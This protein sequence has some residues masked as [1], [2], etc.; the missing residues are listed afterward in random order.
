[1]TIHELLQIIAIG[2]DSQHQWKRDFTNADSLAAEMVAFSNGN[3]GTILIGVDDT[4]A[5]TGL[6]GDD[7][8]RLNQL[9]SNAASQNVR[10]AINP[11]THNVVADN[12]IV[13][14]V[15]IQTGSDKPYQDKDGVFW[16]KSGSDKRKA[17]AREEIKRMFANDESLHADEQP[18]N[19]TSIDDLNLEY[20]TEYFNREN[21]TPLSKQSIPVTT[22]LHNLKI[23][24]KDKLTLAG[25]IVFGRDMQFRVPLATVKAVA[26]FGNSMADTKYIDRR[27]I[28]G[29]L[30]DIYLKCI[31]FT[32]D[33]LR[34]IQVKEG[35]NSQ[36][37][38]EIPL[39]VLQ[40]IIVNA[41][42][43]RDFYVPAQIRLMIFKN[44]VDITS[45]GHLPNSLTT[46]SIKMGMSIIRNFI[47]ASFATRS[48]PYAGLGTG[49][50]RPGLMKT[51]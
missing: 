2:E 3:G 15:T 19:G 6:S 29:K 37:E 50:K 30:E 36:G 20:F 22:L 38:L 21:K 7:V 51:E 27:D 31:S 8:R 23:M 35:F 45:P 17:T 18:V 48:L 42:V 14:V 1:M 10:P 26:F 28:S 5:I 46:E 4:G 44:R 13:M 41:L 33:N 49:I 11:I 25:A 39:S 9:I 24:N 16:V 32:S 40:E 34:I 43:H 12:G 47:L